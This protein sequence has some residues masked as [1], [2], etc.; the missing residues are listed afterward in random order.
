V[1]VHYVKQAESLL[2]QLGFMVNQS[3]TSDL[4]GIHSG[5]LALPA[6]SQANPTDT[7]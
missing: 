3:P 2:E 5:L 1:L 6:A 7:F 4:H